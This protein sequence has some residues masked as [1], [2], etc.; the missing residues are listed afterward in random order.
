VPIF[1]QALELAR[2]GVAPGGSR[3]NLALA[4]D[5]GTTFDAAVDE[6]MRLVLADAQTSGGL[7]I[8]I[9]S[10]DASEYLARVTSARRIGTIT[11][12]GPL[13]VKM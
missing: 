9:T 13:R 5:S 12:N 6:A 8:S 11:Q 1:A 4:V 3:N 7:L 2:N 10:E